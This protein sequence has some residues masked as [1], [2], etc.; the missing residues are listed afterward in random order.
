MVKRSATRCGRCT[1][2]IGD[3]TDDILDLDY[4][5]KDNKVVIMI[6][7]RASVE[8]GIMDN[9]RRMNERE[10]GGGRAK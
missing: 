9:K 6:R 8:M 5:L 1:F 3:G 4:R 2:P 7:L 10:E